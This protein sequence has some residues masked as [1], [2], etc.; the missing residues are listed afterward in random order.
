MKIKELKEILMHYQG[1]EYDDWDLKLWDYNNQ[2]EL[3]WPSGTYSSSKP[4]RSITFPVSV[5]PVDGEEID[6]RM[7]RLI[8]ELNDGLNNEA[9][10]EL[11]EKI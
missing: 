9:S 8:A 7:K 11:M 2:R 1:R 6:S 3:N 4:D 5:E 10:K